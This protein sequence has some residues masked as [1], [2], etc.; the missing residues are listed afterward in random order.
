MVANMVCNLVRKMVCN[1]VRK[2]V[3]NMVIVNHITNYIKSHIFNHIKTQIL[4]QKKNHIINHIMWQKKNPTLTQRWDFVI[5]YTVNIVQNWL[6]S[7]IVRCQFFFGVICD[8]AIM[9]NLILFV[10]QYHLTVSHTEYGIRKTRKHHTG[11][12][13]VHIYLLNLLV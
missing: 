10:V 5:N 3:K 9:R 13:V 6:S 12:L 8:W 7:Q 11:H 1:L 4:T 2:M